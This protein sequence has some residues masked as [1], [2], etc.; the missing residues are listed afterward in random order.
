MAKKSRKVFA[1][2]ATAA[3][4]ASAVAPIASSA[5]GFSDVTKP[6]YKTAIDAL[7][8]AGILNGYENGTFK[9]ENKVTR[10]EVAKVITL[11]RHLE[12][13]TKTP[14]KDVKDG[15]WSTQYINSL[16]AAKLV[17]G[18]E[19]GTFKP[20]GNVTRAEFAKLVV[21]AYG[22][23]LTNAATP[24]TDVKAGNWATP[25]IQ[26]A[27]AN[28]LI[29][30]VTASK[31]DPNAAIKRGDL[32]ILLHRAD[33]KFGD[34]IGNNF[35]GVELVKATNNTTVE[36]TFKNE[37]DVKD[38]QAAKFSI[39]GLTVS[40]AAVKQT[41]S[42]TVVLTTSVQE[43]GKQYTVK[44]GSATL[45]KFIGVSSVLPSEITVN[46]KS[47]QGV[48]GE[49]VTL[50]T[51]VKVKDGESAAG[52]PVTF[53]I[54][55]DSKDNKTIEVEVFT[56][57]KG[58]AEY[59]YTRYYSGVDSVV[60]Y[61]TKKSTVKDNAKVYWASAKQLKIEEVTTGNDLANNTKKSYK[62]KGAA[63]T[64]YYVAIKENLG[65]TPD[66]IS[67][68][69]VLDKNGNYETPYDTT[70]GALKVVTIRTDKD[71]EASFSIYGENVSATPIVYS[72]TATNHAYSA[73]DLQAVAPTVKF[74]LVNALK[75]SV[76][77]E[78]TEK[79]AEYKSIPVAYDD[80][81]AG[82]R[83]YTVTV[84]DKDGKL[85]PEGTVAYV[86]FEKGNI[87]GNVYFST[88]KQNFQAVTDTTTPIAITVG[89]EGKA[90]FRV[91]GSGSKTFVKP[92]VFLNTAGTVSPVAL[93]KTDVQV[94]ADPTYF[95]EAVVKNAVLTVKDV[96]Q[97]DVTSLV[98]GNE[99]YVT[100][101]A[102]DQNGFAY[103]PSNSQYDLPFDVTS[104]FGNVTVKS[105]DGT[106]LNAIQNLGGV[107]TYKVS[108]DANGLA[109][110]R[111]STTTPDTISVNV[112]GANGIL[113]S[114]TAKITF[115]G[116]A[117]TLDRV[118]AATSVKEVLDALNDNKDLKPAFADLTDTQ[119]QEVAQYVLDKR[120]GN[121]YTQKELETAYKTV[122]NQVADADATAKLAAAKTAA[123]KAD[124]D[125]AKYTNDSFAAYT[126]D[127][128]AAN[129]LAEGTTEEKVA[130]TTA[131][132]NAL[133]K[134]KSVVTAD[135][136][137][138]VI[139]FT[140]AIA[141]TVVDLSKVPTTATA[142][143][144]SD[145]GATATVAVVNG[146]STTN[147]TATVTLTTTGTAVSGDTIKITGAVVNGVTKDITLTHDG[148]GWTLAAPVEFK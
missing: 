88:G 76:K 44:S 43:G 54:Q 106:T 79:A 61:A 81:S 48:Y 3:L 80:V 101:Q 47:S 59:S 68:V 66:K 102:V 138:L 12:E 121:G 131:I 52:I 129:Q 84:T 120:P 87:S 22:L 100:Y 36:V 134:L 18:Y 30:G 97:N 93:D 31:F 143:I 8:E 96:K 91:A 119:K 32:A 46:T 5:A 145:S 40:N 141:G 56:N 94:V 15:Y 57:E 64:D 11:I 82:G 27:Y 146:T 130:K 103:A 98:V 136:S 13:G 37:V 77:A 85:A 10:G 73:T 108:S 148:S 116:Q 4:V 89:K 63:N 139:T 111:I 67:D 126:T 14:F 92:T 9:P 105:L 1:T 115:T 123:T 72:T 35:P 99:A 113:P 109:T 112:I 127:I 144:A 90:T 107:K 28:G 21:D 26:T 122:T 65:V 20:E 78:G 45:G 117:S 55:N 53:N 124:T 118:N 2:T 69:Y 133:A 19:D 34:V 104:T 147:G 71:G 140:P 42:K 49:E 142:T 70:T 74:S 39:E 125:K 50:S 25:Y 7:A 33:S 38:V 114:N 137:D 58:V 6:E 128:T 62:V 24:F 23:T 110:I 75:V 83:T 132:N 41:D 86:A 17:N 95:T 16:Y 135:A 51:Q 60:A 29:K